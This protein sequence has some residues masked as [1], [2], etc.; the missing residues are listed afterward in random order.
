MDAARE[1]API[2]GHMRSASSPPP[3]GNAYTRLHYGWVQ[4]DTVGP[5]GSPATLRSWCYQD[6]GSA[7]EAGNTVPVTLQSFAVE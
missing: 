1:G 7:I 6:D 2:R 5:N 4:I 3:P